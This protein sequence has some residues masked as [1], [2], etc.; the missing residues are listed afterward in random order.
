MDQKM[1]L[2]FSKNAMLIEILCI[3]FLKGPQELYA[4]NNYVFDCRINAS[5]V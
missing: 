2:K 4:F 1:L 5:Y 3:T